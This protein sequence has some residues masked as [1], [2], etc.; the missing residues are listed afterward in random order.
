MLYQI[1]DVAV[2]AVAAKK[3][4]LVFPEQRVRRDRSYADLK[5]VPVPFG[6]AVANGGVLAFSEQSRRHG[7]QDRTAGHIRFVIRGLAGGRIEIKR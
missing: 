1:S 6:E 2:I 4:H 5:A 7:A 3:L